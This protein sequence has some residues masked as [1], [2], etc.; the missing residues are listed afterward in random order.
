MKFNFP[1]QAGAICEWIY[2]ETEAIRT[3]R[4]L[5][6]RETKI[7]EARSFPKRESPGSRD[8]PSPLQIPRIRDLA[9]NCKII[10]G[11]QQL[12]GKI[13]SRK[14]LAARFSCRRPKTGTMPAV[15]ASTMMK[16]AKHGAQGHP[17]HENERSCGKRSWPSCQHSADKSNKTVPGFSKPRPHAE[18]S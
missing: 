14:D 10:H 18:I 17:S 12:T 3:H 7:F 2:L 6:L 11:A 9:E 16:Q 1:G 13:L 4:K 8:I 15:V 5:A